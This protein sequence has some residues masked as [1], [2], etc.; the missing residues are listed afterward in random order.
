MTVDHDPWH[1]AEDY[2]PSYDAEPY[3]PSHDAKKKPRETAHSRL[4]QKILESHRLVADDGGAIYRFDGARWCELS[5]TALSQIIALTEG[6]AFTT[7]RRR[8]E[9]ASHL[10]AT[11]YRKELEWDR[12]SLHEVACAN[13][14][15]DARYGRLRPHD[16][17]DYLETVIPHE[18]RPGAECP[19]WLKA[20]DRWFNDAGGVEGDRAAALQLFFGYCTLSHARFKKAALLYGVADSGKS[21]ALYVLQEMLGESNCCTLSV[22]QMHDPAYLSILKGKMLNALFD[23]PADALIKDG[24]FKTLVSTEEPITI[25]K[26]YNDP[27]Q[28]RS[29]SKHIIATNHLPTIFDRSEATLS[30]ILIVPFTSPL[31]ADEQDRDLRDKLRPELSGI[32]LWAIEGA[33]LLIEAGGQFEQPS[34]ASALIAEMRTDTNPI[35]VFLQERCQP[36]ICA[37]LPVSTLCEQYN[38][39]NR[40]NRRVSVRQ[41]GRML[42][43]QGQVLKNVR[44]GHRVMLSLIGW[45]IEGHTPERIAISQDNALSDAGE[46]PAIGEKES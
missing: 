37:A 42:R 16:P 38:R 29:F 6:E 19:T 45:S 26:L 32:L 18:Y 13:G 46:I 24:G 28:Y 39:W 20:L 3:D 31:N 33:R 8:R 34:G 25:K 1:D 17:D 36:E 2:D 12:A 7:E 27:V 40:G 22:D 35:M 44:S 10:A 9:V 23:L 4:A 11:S 14:V 43:A 5:K 30:R 41:L 15:V 21:Q